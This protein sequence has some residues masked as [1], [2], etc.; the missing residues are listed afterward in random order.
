MSL[1]CLLR[2]AGS[3]RSMV[4]ALSSTVSRPPLDLPLVVSVCMWSSSGFEAASF[5]SGEVKQTGKTLPQAMGLAV[6][7]MMAGVGVPV[8]AS[9]RAI[10]RRI[11]RPS[12]LDAL[13]ARILRRASGVPRRPGPRHL[14]V[15]RRR[16]VIPRAS[17]RLPVHVGAQRA[18]NGLQGAAASMA[19][20]RLEKRATPPQRSAS[21]RRRC[22]ARSPS[23]LP[24]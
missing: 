8:L 20:E 13:V 9:C 23:R 10:L 22:S 1:L 12:R 11:R 18:G 3:W 4:D 7:L 16:Y 21:R 2:P 6:V 5:V 17:Q 14:D 24:T 15:P 19:A